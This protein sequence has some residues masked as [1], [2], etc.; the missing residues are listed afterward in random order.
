MPRYR[1]TTK[2]GVVIERAAASITQ[3][4]QELG[5]QDKAMADISYYKDI[6][7]VQ[8]YLYLLHRQD[9][10]EGAKPEQINTCVVVAANPESAKELVGDES[11][12]V[13]ICLGPAY[14][15][16]ADGVLCAETIPDLGTNIDVNHAPITM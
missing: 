12:R 7:V 5:S 11:L 15:S 6:T 14:A 3:V 2:D 4:L 9:K 10:V 8:Y 13:T 16:I 1:F